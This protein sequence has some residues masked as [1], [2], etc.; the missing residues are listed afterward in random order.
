MPQFA[1]KARD[2]SGKLIAGKLEAAHR[3]IVAD[4][5]R[6]MGYFVSSIE[7][8]KATGEALEAD[9]FERFKK[10]KSQDLVI[11]NNQ[12]ATMISSGLTLISSLNVLSQQIENKKLKEVIINVRDDIESG[13]SFS[14]AL[15]KHPKVFSPL[16]VNMINAGETGGALE[17]I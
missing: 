16:L 4:K 6:S 17:E 9:I 13:T 14:A 15:D 8:E 7:Q 2:N 12:L 1:Y 3:Q 10:V 5:L 11:F